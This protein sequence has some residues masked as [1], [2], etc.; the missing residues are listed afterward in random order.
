MR[1]YELTFVSTEVGRGTSSTGRAVAVANNLVFIERDKTVITSI[2][3]RYPLDISFNISYDPTNTTRQGAMSLSI[4]GLKES[5]IDLISQPNTQVVLKVGYKSRDPNIETRPED[6]SI[7]FSGDVINLE[8]DNTPGKKETKLLCRASKLG[9]KPLLVTYSSLGT[10]KDRLIQMI[11]DTQ[12]RNPE[13]DISNALVSLEVIASEEPTKNELLEKL[14]VVIF[15]EDNPALAEYS[16]PLLND[17]V[18]GSYTAQ[19]TTLEELQK[20][21]KNFDMDVSVMNRELYF[22]RK[23]G[24]VPSRNQVQARL[25]EN[26]LSAPRRVV[27]ASKGPVGSITS[28]YEYKCR[29]LLSPQIKLNTALV[30]NVT[31]NTNGTVDDK[32]FPLKVNKIIH[33]GRYYGKVWYTDVVCS[34]NSE[35]YQDSPL[36]SVEYDHNIHTKSN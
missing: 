29:L 1:E 14:G 17:P 33:R 13:I 27:D 30:S 8:V 11:K 16:A 22:V 3:Q 9:S 15:S 5:N 10:H 26:L 4:F 31:R 34:E 28:R 24:A 36:K 6:L 20:Y 25:G 23:G 18:T 7:L 2:N 19:G 21:A 12:V 32:E 35:S